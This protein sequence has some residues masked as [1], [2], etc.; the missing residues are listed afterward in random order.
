MKNVQALSSG[1]IDVLVMITQFPG[2]LMD[3]FLENHRI[4]VEPHH[5]QKEEVAHL[6]LLDDDVNALFFDQSKSDVKQVC[7]KSILTI[8]L[9]EIQ[10]L[11]D[12]LLI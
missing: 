11:L 6:G 1:L 10:A 8:K 5:V 9:H 4:N 12:F 7:L 2:K 3:N